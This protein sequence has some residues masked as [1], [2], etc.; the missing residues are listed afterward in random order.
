MFDKPKVINFL[1]FLH[2]CACVV[3]LKVTSLSLTLSLSFSASHTGA[4]QNDYNATRVWEPLKEL[5]HEDESIIDGYLQLACSPAVLY[6]GRNME[7]AYHFLYQLGGSVK[8]T[9]SDHMTCHVIVV[10]NYY[11]CC[12]RLFVCCCLG[13]L[14]CPRV[15][16]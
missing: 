14:C 10:T 12:R 16:P 6:G 1:T 4:A 11:L 8:V 15:T 2:T 9:G 7:L 13:S 3:Y 5:T